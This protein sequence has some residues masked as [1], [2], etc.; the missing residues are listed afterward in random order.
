MSR[1]GV[2]LSSSQ[3]DKP[4]LDAFRTHL[5]RFERDGHLRVSDNQSILPGDDRELALRTTIDESYA[6]IVL[7]SSDFLNDDLMG[8]QVPRLVEAAEGQRLRLMPLFVR[9][10]LPENAR[11][12]GCIDY[13]LYGL[14][15][16]RI[17]KKY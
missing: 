15:S 1:L 11:C 10:A 9:P 17:G 13:F 16:I 2:F 7:V 6:A 5:K 8:E 3:S 4:Y 14:Y 12:C